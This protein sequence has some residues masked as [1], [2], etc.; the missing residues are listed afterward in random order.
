MVTAVLHC[1]FNVTTSTRAAAAFWRDLLCAVRACATPVSACANALGVPVFARVSSQFM[2][3]AD[4]LGDRIAIMARGTLRVVGSS[5]FLKG[6]FGIGY[7]LVVVTEVGDLQACFAVLRSRALLLLSLQVVRGARA[8]AHKRRCTCAW[9]LWSCVLLP[10]EP[11]TAQRRAGSGAHARAHGRPRGVRRRGARGA[12]CAAAP[13]RPAPLRQHVRGAGGTKVCAGAAHPLRPMPPFVPAPPSLAPCGSATTAA[14]VPLSTY[15]Q[16]HTRVV[17]FPCPCTSAHVCARVCVRASTARDLTPSASLG[18]LTFGISVT[19]L[20]EVFLRLAEV[21]EEGEQQAALST[22]GKGSAL[23]AP[24]HNLGCACTATPCCAPPRHPLSCPA[25]PCPALRRPAR[26][27]VTPPPPV[28]A[29]PATF[30]HNRPPLLRFVWPLPPPYPHH[31]HRCAL[32]CAFGRWPTPSQPSL[33]LCL[34]AGPPL[35]DWPPTTA[36]PCARHPPGV[37][38]AWGTWTWRRA[39]CRRCPAPLCTSARAAQGH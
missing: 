10:A 35:P 26:L 13:G 33:F 4:L 22:L 15:T 37:R 25:H 6:R 21:V 36:L 28:P 1:G 12:V 16:P 3:E 19:S 23:V 9:S 2:D 5:L 17:C 38:S 29:G 7:H 11:G 30:A 31:H 18:I 39:W 27:C 34:G 14:P 8:R 32:G 24:G 20:E